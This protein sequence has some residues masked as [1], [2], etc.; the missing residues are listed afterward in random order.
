MNSLHNEI[1][2]I[3]TDTSSLVSEAK[4]SI[5]E[6]RKITEEE[7]RHSQFTKDSINNQNNEFETALKNIHSK[8]NDFMSTITEEVSENKASYLDEIAAMQVQLIKVQD[9][10]NLKKSEINL[11]IEE[12]LNSE[13]D[14]INTHLNALAEKIKTAE[15]QTDERLIEHKKE[16]T[17]K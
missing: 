12:A 11:K 17:T 7:L 13:Q 2:V 10:F 15:S 4:N 5:E 6:S 3:K 16:I 8:L 1:G 9:D 14:T